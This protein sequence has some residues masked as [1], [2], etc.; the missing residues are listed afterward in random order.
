MHST[1]EPPVSPEDFIGIP[2]SVV[3]AEGEHI[4]AASAGTLTEVPLAPPFHLSDE[5][6][7]LLLPDDIGMELVDI[8]RDGDLE[9]MREA[10]RDGLLVRGRVDQEGR[11]QRVLAVEE[12]AVPLEALRPELPYAAELAVSSGRDALRQVAELEHLKCTMVS[13]LLDDEGIERVLR[14]PE[15]LGVSWSVPKDR[16]V[17]ADPTC[18]WSRHLE[19]GRAGVDLAL[20]QEYE[21]L[22]A[23]LRP[24]LLRAA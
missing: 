7:Y 19:R 1:P 8:M 2:L 9:L 3:F 17:E 22:V 6:T 21:E 10:M 20:F 16:P 11:G 4:A 5:D 23:V 14:R 12:R 15:Y 18:V 13:G 24:V